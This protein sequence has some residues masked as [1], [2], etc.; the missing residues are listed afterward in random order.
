M[1]L[2]H[3]KDITASSKFKL[4]EKRSHVNNRQS[5]NRKVNVPVIEY[6]HFS[7]TLVICGDVLATVVKQRGQGNWHIEVNSQNISF[8]LVYNTQF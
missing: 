8:E 4:M 1:I 6:P 3:M 5:Y 7:C 2:Q